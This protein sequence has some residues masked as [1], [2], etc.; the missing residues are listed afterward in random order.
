MRSGCWT[1]LVFC[2]LHLRNNYWV[3]FSFRIGQMYFL[4]YHVCFCFLL[5]F[6]IFTEIW[7]FLDPEHFDVVSL[8]WNPSLDKKN[9]LVRGWELSCLQGKKSLVFKTGKQPSL[10]FPFC[11]RFFLSSFLNMIVEWTSDHYAPINFAYEMDWLP[12]F[13]CCS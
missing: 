5:K 11:L 12:S 8:C 9:W 2:Y 3:E 13:L 7:K 10:S 1:M 6:Q 4:D